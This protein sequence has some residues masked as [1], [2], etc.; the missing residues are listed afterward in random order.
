MIAHF[1]HPLTTLRAFRLLLALLL[2]LALGP[3]A[4]AL[5]AAAFDGELREAMAVWGVPGMAV[6]VVEQGSLVFARGYGT[7]AVS[8]GRP[9]TPDTL[10]ANASTTK[11]MIAAAAL[12]LVD[13]GRLSLDDPVGQ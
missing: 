7:T 3:R 5:D 13:E 12:I 2:G 8:D 4:L 6:S 10:F 11:A 9:V 1:P